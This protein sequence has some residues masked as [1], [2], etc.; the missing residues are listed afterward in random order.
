[1]HFDRRLY[2]AVL[3]ND[4][5]GFLDKVFRILA[6]GQTYVPAWYIHRRRAE[7]RDEAR[8]A[9]IVDQNTDVVAPCG[10]VMRPVQSW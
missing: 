3:R 10:G 4:F 6:P 1:M 7:G 5:R 9:G 8:N 2:E